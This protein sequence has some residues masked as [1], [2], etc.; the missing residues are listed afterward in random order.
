MIKKYRFLIARR[1][2][3]ISIMVLYVIA[4]VYGINILMGNLSSSLVLKTIPLS[5]PYR[6]AP[7]NYSTANSNGA[8]EVINASV[9]NDLANNNNIV[10]ITTL[11][12]K[13]Y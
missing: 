2:T 5:D 9:L 8:V 4:N 13:N 12:Q 7:Y 10:V 11:Y 3:Q 6:G 1:I